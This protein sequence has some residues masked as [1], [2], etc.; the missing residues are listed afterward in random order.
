MKGNFAF[1]LISLSGGIETVVY[2]SLSMT[3]GTGK[4]RTASALARITT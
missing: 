4:I 1:R 2:N 3:R